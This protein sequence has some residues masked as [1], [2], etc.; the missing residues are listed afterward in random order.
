LEINK[1]CWL[2]TIVKNDKTD[3]SDIWIP[4]IDLLLSHKDEIKIN[5]AKQ[6]EIDNQTKTNPLNVFFTIHLMR[7]ML[8]LPTNRLFVDRVTG[9]PISRSKYTTMMHKEMQKMGI[10]TFFTVYS[11]KHVVIEKLVKNGTT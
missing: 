6:K 4:N 10:L 11:L 8:I 7:T 2:R 1:G 5:N 3:I 9:N